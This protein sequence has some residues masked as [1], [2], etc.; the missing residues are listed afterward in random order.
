MRRRKRKDKDQGKGR[1]RQREGPN[2]RRR[3]EGSNIIRSG[4]DGEREGRGDGGDTSHDTPLD[5]QFGECYEPNEYRKNTKEARLLWL[6]SFE[7]KDK[8]AAM[9]LLLLPIA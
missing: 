3:G 9:W 7:S 5:L 4:R 2:R 1:R 6:A 8:L